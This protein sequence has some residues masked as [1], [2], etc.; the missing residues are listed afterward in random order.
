MLFDRKSNIAVA[1]SIST[2]SLFSIISTIIPPISYPIALY[3]YNS[4]SVISLAP[5]VHLL[6]AVCSLSSACSTLFYFFFSSVL[7]YL[8]SSHLFPSSL[9]SHSSESL[10]IPI[11]LFSYSH[12]TTVSVTNTFRRPSFC[13]FSSFLFFFFFYLRLTFSSL[14]VPSSTYYFFFLFLFTFFSPFLHICFFIP[15]TIVLLLTVKE[16][17][18]SSASLFHHVL[19]RHLCCLC[20]RCCFDSRAG[21]PPQALFLSLHHGSSNPV[22]S[23][24]FLLVA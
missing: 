15:P 24:Q 11:P 4:A 1:Y 18:P 9:L 13:R 14:Q 20:L 19:R 5:T 8:I 21:S 2:S 7:F 6:S 16:S 12:S 10:F 17:K 23:G 3:C 22:G